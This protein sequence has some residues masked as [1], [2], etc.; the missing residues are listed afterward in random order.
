M[1]KQLIAYLKNQGLSEEQINL[2]ISTISNP[3]NI[4]V[5]KPLKDGVISNFTYTEKLLKLN[6]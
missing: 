5:I 1:N 2:F 3:S 4:E 6:K